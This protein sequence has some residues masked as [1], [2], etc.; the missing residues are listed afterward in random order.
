MNT[1]L[2][3][4]LFLIPEGME[5]IHMADKQNAIQE[6]EYDNLSGEDIWVKFQKQYSTHISGVLIYSK[7]H[8]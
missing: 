6:T 3:S 4:L 5:K 1:F 8:S 7:M 2:Q